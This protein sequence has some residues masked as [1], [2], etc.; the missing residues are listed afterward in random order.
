MLPLFQHLLEFNPHEETAEPTL[1]CG[2]DLGGAFVPHVLEPGQ[3]AHLEEHLGER[4]SDLR[5]A[6]L[7]NGRGLGGG[8]GVAVQEQ[9]TIFQKGPSAFGDPGADV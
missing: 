7:T 9:R 1:Q 8:G 3:D 5:I 2:H 6:Q 4:H